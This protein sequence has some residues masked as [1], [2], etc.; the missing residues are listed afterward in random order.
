[1]SSRLEKALQNITNAPSER[2]VEIA[3]YLGISRDDFIQVVNYA[4]DVMVKHHPTVN[5][6]KM[7]EDVAN[8]TMVVVAFAQQ[9]FNGNHEDD[10]FLRNL[11][12]EAFSHTN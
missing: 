2:L 10:E 6:F 4:T 7:A 1:M 9:G 5:E 3:D 8:F 11:P 12:G